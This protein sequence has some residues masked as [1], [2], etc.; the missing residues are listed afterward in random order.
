M[1]VQ[2]DRKVVRARFTFPV[3]SQPGWRNRT[4]FPGKWLWRHFLHEC[5]FMLNKI[6]SFVVFVSMLLWSTVVWNFESFSTAQYSVPTHFLF[7]LCRMPWTYFLSIWRR[8]F[9]CSPE[10]VVVSGFHGHNF[11][12]IALKYLFNSEFGKFENTVTS[13]YYVCPSTY[14]SRC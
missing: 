10:C 6:I 4:L 11:L 9:L 2:H 8:N 7:E 12:L 14:Q 13:T 1:A 5:Q 3:N